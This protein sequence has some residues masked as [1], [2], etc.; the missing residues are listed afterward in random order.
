MLILKKQR[1]KSSFIPL[2]FLDA[3][4]FTRPTFSTQKQTLVLLNPS[5]NFTSFRVHINV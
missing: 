2:L 1:R 5:M 4:K 3:D